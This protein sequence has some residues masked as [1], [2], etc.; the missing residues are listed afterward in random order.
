MEIPNFEI[1]FFSN[2]WAWGGHS[3]N[4]C[5]SQHPNLLQ[6]YLVIFISVPA[7][8]NSQQCNMNDFCNSNPRPS[9]AILDADSLISWIKG[10][11]Q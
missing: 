3:S 6:I 1:W 5:R 9:E 7:V 10:K 2:K 11:F 8:S 4:D